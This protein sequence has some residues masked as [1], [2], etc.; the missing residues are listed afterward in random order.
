MGAGK[1]SVGRLLAERLDRP[2]RD[3]DDWLGRATGRTA[4]EIEAAGGA[5]ALHP[6][7]S[8][9]LLEA[10]GDPTPSVIAAAASVVDDPTAVEGLRRP[11][12]VV[13]WL[14]A[15]PATLVARA[16]TSGH[17]PWH[18]S[19]PLDHL[20][21]RDARRDPARA[22]LAAIVVDVTDLGPAA[23][24]DRIVGQLEGDPARSTTP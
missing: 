17:R 22:S 15:D 24:V 7:E 4:A 16:V 20:R 1:T 23:A 11:G 12:T 18:G 14:R 2:F 8:R 9:A 21:E 10:L 6:L 19:A 5:D 13:V 3:S